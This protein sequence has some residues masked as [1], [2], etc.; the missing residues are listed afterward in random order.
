VHWESWLLRLALLATLAF[1]LVTRNTS[2]AVVAVEGMVMSLAPLLVQRL[3]GT[4]VPRPLEFVFVLAMALQ[5]I[6]ESTKLFEIFTYWDKIVHPSEVALTAMMV[7]WLLLGYSHALGKR[8]PIHVAATLGVLLGIAVGGFWEFVEMASDWFG[9]ANL[10]KSNGDTMTDIIANNLGA[11]AATLLGLWIYQHAL[12]PRQREEMGRI[13]QWLAHGP[14]RLLDRHGRV[15]GGVLTVAIGGV[16]VASQVMDRGVPGIPGGL[17]S[18]PDQQWDFVSATSPTLTLSGDWVQDQRGMCR[19]NLE[20]VKPGSETM[21]V[22]EL[23]PGAAY[24]LNAEPFAVHARYFEERPA[25]GQGTQMDAGLAFGIR[26][27]NN[28]LLLEASA[29]HDYLRLDRY[30]HGKRRDIRET[31]LRLHGNDWHVLDLNV[32][33]STVTAGLDGG[34][35][36][37]VDVGANE[38]AGPIGLWART[39]AASCF[40]DAVAQV[41]A[42]STGAAVPVPGQ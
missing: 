1:Q 42:G 34:Q 15:V 29:L 41:G 40:S 14:S 30:V 2:G 13:A 22:L 39:S 31:M 20:S 24:G 32:V 18:G 23:A 5:F 7:G 6:S 28:F 16:L 35:R 27:S 10:Q 19:V 26:D 36:F 17:D 21:G 33:G 25:L 3:S 4:H 11:M 8:L 37:T 38:T 9:D 12:Q